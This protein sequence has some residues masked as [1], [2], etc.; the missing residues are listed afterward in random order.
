MEKNKN[1]K[2]PWGN[3]SCEEVLRLIEKERERELTPFERNA[4]FT[5][6]TICDE[7]REVQRKVLDELIGDRKLNEE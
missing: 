5:H 3:L 6:C 2:G 1:K 7:C 4:V